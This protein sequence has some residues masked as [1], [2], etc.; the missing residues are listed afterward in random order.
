MRAALALGALA[1][2]GVLGAPPAAASPARPA[3][4]GYI[5]C[6]DSSEC[7]TWECCVLGTGRFSLPRCVPMPDLGET[8]RPGRE[9][10][11]N[12]TL[13]YPDGSEVFLS[14]VHLQLCP[15]TPGL[16]C[17]PQQAACAAA[18]EQHENDVDLD[19]DLNGL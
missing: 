6:E 18:E 19:G 4:P 16:R 5:K 7:G 14:A 1:L 2:L 10:P 11:E 17:D 9:R 3:R 12:V 13:S 15:C 8:C